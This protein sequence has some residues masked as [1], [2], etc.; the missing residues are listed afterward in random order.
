MEVGQELLYYCS[1][2]KLKLAHIIEVK[3]QGK[4]LKVM[5]KTCKKVHAYK[6]PAEKKSSSAASK[7][8]ALQSQSVVKKL[9][10]AATTSSHS[11]EGKSSL[12]ATNATL[13]SIKS[14]FQVSEIILHPKFGVGIVKEVK[15][16]KILVIFEEEGKKLLV[17][18]TP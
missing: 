3:Y 2:C 17:Q 1:K 13:Y 8:A 16:D 12:D 9:V 15:G 7:S 11:E 4:I 6:D 14:S 18:K 5:C 10:S